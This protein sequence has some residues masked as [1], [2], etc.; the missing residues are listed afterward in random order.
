MAITTEMEILED[1]NSVNRELSWVQTSS[2][3]TATGANPANRANLNLGADASAMLRCL[4]PHGWI[5]GKD[6]LNFEVG[7]P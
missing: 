2:V 1:A 4:P 3:Q 7:M 5:L 6:P